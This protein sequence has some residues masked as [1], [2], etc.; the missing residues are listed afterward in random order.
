MSTPQG[1][2]RPELIQA[3]HSAARIER[4]RTVRRLLQRILHRMGRQTLGR[5]A[6]TAWR[7]SAH[8]AIGDCR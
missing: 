5:Q 4:A 1:T 8:P 2:A 6:P 7:A 3:L